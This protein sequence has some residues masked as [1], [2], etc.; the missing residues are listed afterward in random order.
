MACNR[1]Q[2]KYQGISLGRATVLCKVRASQVEGGAP[3]S[4]LFQ[5]ELFGFVHRLGKVREMVVAVRY[6][7][8]GPDIPML[9]TPLPPC[10]P[11]PIL[12]PPPHTHT[13]E[14]GTSHCSCLE[15]CFPCTLF[16]PCGLQ[17][18]GRWGKNVQG[19]NH[20]CF[21]GLEIYTFLSS[22]TSRVTSIQ[23]KSWVLMTEQMVLSPDGHSRSLCYQ[24][25][26]RQMTRLRT[27]NKMRQTK[28]SM[29]A[30][31]FVRVGQF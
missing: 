2:Q 29:H 20:S 8:P 21:M 31:K 5:K 25:T 16:R 17:G 26:Y 23:Q 15:H 22:K 6:R 14:L 24:C 19:C 4:K 27:K 1:M 12:S 9:S 13:N 28:V 30:D 3:N 10:P 11:T 7:Q 18:G